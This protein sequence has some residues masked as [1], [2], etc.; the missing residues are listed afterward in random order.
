MRVFPVQTLWIHN[1]PLVLI[2]G[3]RQ[4]MTRHGAFLKE[5]PWKKRVLGWSKLVGNYNK[6]IT[7]MHGALTKVKRNYAL[8]VIYF[9]VHLVLI[10]CPQTSCFVL[11]AR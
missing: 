2:G 9:R 5:T 10:K 4:D 7:I 11:S 6:I 1:A 8:L 3:W